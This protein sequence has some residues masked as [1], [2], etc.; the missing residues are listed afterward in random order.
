[1]NA[2][3][4][5]RDF[6]RRLARTGAALGLLG[7]AA[8]ALRPPEGGPACESPGRTQPRK[9]L[10]AACPLYAGCERPGRVERTRGNGHA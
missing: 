4:D 8:A 1:M 7:S 3:L 10:C 9:G 5:R 2:G 6:L